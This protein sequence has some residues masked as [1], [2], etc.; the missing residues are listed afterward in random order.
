MPHTHARQ[1]VTRFAA[2]YV[3]RA[4]LQGPYGSSRLAAFWCLSFLGQEPGS[5]HAREPLEMLSRCLGRRA[6]GADVISVLEQDGPVPVP[7]AALVLDA[8][9]FGAPDLPD[10]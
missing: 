5:P 2:E 6:G 9:G 8:Y 7:V 10:A 1:L 3:Q 4:E